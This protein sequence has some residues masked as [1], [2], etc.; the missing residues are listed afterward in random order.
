MTLATLLATPPTAYRLLTDFVELKKGDVIVQ[1]AANSAVGKYVIQL[2]HLWGFKTINVVR[3]RPN[4]V[5]LKAELRGFGADEVYTDDEFKKLP[6]VMHAKLALD[7]VGGQSS[8]LL[9]SMLAPGGVLVNYG[10]MSGQP[11]QV[12][13]RELIF[14]NVQVRGFLLKNFYE[15]ASVEDRTE[16]FAELVKMFKEGTLK[17]PSHSEHLLDNVVDAVKASSASTNSKQILCMPQGR[18]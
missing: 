6:E 12:S 8:L 15:K 1:N 9:S 5:T 4:V 13:P 7:C 2:A 10:S 3:N 16:T 17:T 14:K 18:R 11:V